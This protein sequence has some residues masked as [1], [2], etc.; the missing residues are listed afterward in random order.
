MGRI[1]AVGQPHHITQR[2]NL[3]ADVFFSPADREMYVA[4]LRHYSEWFQLS[5]LG[6]CLMTNH[7]H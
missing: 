4:L 5:V 7:V 6:Y 2:G 3:R 1:V